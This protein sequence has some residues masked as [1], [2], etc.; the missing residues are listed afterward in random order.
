MYPGRPSP[1]PFGVPVRRPGIGLR[2]VPTPSGRRVNKRKRGARAT[3]CVIVLFLKKRRRGPDD[4]WTE[5]GRRWTWMAASV[6]C[7]PHRRTPGAFRHAACCA[8]SPHTSD[9]FRR[10]AGFR[11]CCPTSVPVRADLRVEALSH[12]DLDPGRRLLRRGRRTVYHDRIRPRAPDLPL[13]VRRWKSSDT[14]AQGRCS[15]R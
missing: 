7:L 6:S 10:R 2:G 11:R 1:I 15:L 14:S 8:I 9:Q 3:S 12:A 5:A 4:M 13:Q